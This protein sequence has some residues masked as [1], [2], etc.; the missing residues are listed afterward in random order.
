MLAETL[1]SEDGHNVFTSPNAYVAQQSF[2]CKNLEVKVDE[3]F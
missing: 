1:S 2:P 3:W